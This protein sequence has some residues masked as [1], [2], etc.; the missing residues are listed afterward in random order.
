M[1]P[2]KDELLPLWRFRTPEVARESAAALFDKFLA[3]PREGNFAG[4]DMARKL[5][6]V[7]STLAR[8][9][10]NHAG[11]KKDAGPVPDDR[12]GRSSAHGRAEL[13]RV[14]EGATPAQREKAETAAIFTARWDEASANPRYALLRTAHLE[15][16]AS[17]KRE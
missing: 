11:G 17:A 12:K 16:Y 2:Y 7:G 4:A 15:R 10:A 13:P 14:A 8:R 5:L 3:H 9:F 1:P 6:Q